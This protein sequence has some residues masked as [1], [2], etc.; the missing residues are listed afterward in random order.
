MLS[1]ELFKIV[2]LEVNSPKEDQW[3]K[4]IFRMNIPLEKVI[5]SLLKLQLKIHVKRALQPYQ[6]TG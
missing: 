2:L 1:D 5:V 4:P 3:S 6:Q